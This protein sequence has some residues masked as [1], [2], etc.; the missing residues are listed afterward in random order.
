LQKL[1]FLPLIS[2]FSYTSK[3]SIQARMSQFW[4]TQFLFDW[5][6]HY[7]FGLKAQ[8]LILQRYFVIW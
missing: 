7:Q 8:L 4:Q 2:N 1:T 6:I 5:R 3:N